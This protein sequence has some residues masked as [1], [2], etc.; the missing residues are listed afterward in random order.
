MDL[1]NRC[2]VN[3]NAFG[4]GFTIEL[5]GMSETGAYHFKRNG[6]KTILDGSW[7]HEK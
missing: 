4:K 6:I 2:T 3:G 5:E 1:Y 7:Q